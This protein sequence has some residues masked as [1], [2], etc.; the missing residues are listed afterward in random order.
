MPEEK[1][2][3]VV[4]TPPET[5]SV[6]VVEPINAPAEVSQTP[7]ELSVESLIS[8]AIVNNTPVDTL[9]RLLAMRRE[10]KAEAAK[11]LFD[12]DMAAF[13][14]DCP[15]INKTK[16]VKTKS[17]QTAYKYAPLDVIV[18]QV[19]D[20]LNKHGFSYAI[21]TETMEG[22]VKV[23]CITK[24]KAGHSENNSVEVPLGSKTEIMSNTQVVAAALTFAKRYAF[25]N[26]FG[27][28]TG[29]DDDD[30]VSTKDVE[31]GARRPQNSQSGSYNRPASNP[32][33]PPQKAAPQAATDEQKRRIF[34]LGKDLNQTPEGTKD[35]IKSHFKLDHFNDLL[36]KDAAAMIRALDKKKK[37]RQDEQPDAPAED[38]ETEARKVFDVEDDGGEVC[39]PNE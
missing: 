8:Q 2:P 19:K 26:A 1:E 9:E 15:V 10:L 6:Q 24:H 30:A 28:L 31:Q 18:A 34:A 7:R 4:E 22:K 38:L 37:A 3:E 23:T 29:D 25:C 39:A 20:L 27:I 13:Q 32:T 12:A 5:Q 21:Q 14:G 36:F 33:T 17:G 16:G 35:F 11:E